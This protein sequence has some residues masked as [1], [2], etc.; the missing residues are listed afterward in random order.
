MKAEKT[1]SFVPVSEK[2]IAGVQQLQNMLQVKVSTAAE[3]LGV[4]A[5]WQLD[6][7]RGGFVPPVG[8]PTTEEGHQ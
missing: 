5:G 1:D 6:L 2:F 7:Q 4:P 8:P 3:L